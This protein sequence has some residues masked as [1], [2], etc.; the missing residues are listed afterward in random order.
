L[1]SENNPIAT[2]ASPMTMAG[3]G[4]NFSVSNPLSGAVTISARPDVPLPPAP[5][6]QQL[7]R[8]IALLTAQR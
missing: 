2:V 5:P 4:P 7:R 1:V 6:E 8:S 3:R